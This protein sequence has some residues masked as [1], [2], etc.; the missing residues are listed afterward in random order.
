MP[1]VFRRERTKSYPRELLQSC[2]KI[3]LAKD[4]EGC[5]VGDG[6]SEIPGLVSPISE[7]V[8]T[9]IMPGRG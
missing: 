5:T 1:P 8:S 7:D 6:A 2:N 9:S 4:G 3:V